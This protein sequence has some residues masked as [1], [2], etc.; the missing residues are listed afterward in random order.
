M[1]PKRFLDNGVTR[2]IELEMVSF[3]MKWQIGNGPNVRIAG[4]QVVVVPWISGWAL[5]PDLNK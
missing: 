3:N 1:E 2:M 4:L 5:L